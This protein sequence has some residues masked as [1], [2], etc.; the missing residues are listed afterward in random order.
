MHNEVPVKPRR[1]KLD[2]QVHRADQRSDRDDST[3]KIFA[4]NH[5]KKSKHRRSLELDNED[6]RQDENNDD[7]YAAGDDKTSG[8]IS[9]KY[10]LRE[11]EKLSRENNELQEK[12]LS[13]DV[14]MSKKNNK[15]KEKLNSVQTLNEEI[16]EENATFKNQYQE[17]M[18]QFR[19]CQ[20][21]LEVC[22]N[23]QK[24]AELNDIVGRQKNEIV[25]LSKSNRELN[26]D[27]NMMKNVVYRYVNL[28]NLFLGK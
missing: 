26:E 11:N 17:L 2:V 9:R 7:S 10:L 27:L 3:R 12:L 8:K 4:A 5:P 23:C 6:L 15:F 14:Y 19:A 21:E 25:S 18:A 16:A 20:N 22:R 1:K 24:C 13:M 28:L